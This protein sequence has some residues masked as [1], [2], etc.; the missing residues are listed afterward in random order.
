MLR[1]FKT[2]GI[3]ILLMSG[4]AYGQTIEAPASNFEAGVYTSDIDLEI[5]HSDPEVQIY[6]TLNGSDPTTG[7][8]LY[9]G[10][11]TLSNR[12][13]D[14]N[15]YATIPTNPSFSFPHGNYTE[16]RANNRGWLEPLDEVYKVNVVRFRAFKPGFAPSDIITQTFM[17]DPAG[18]D[19]YSFPLVSIVVDSMDIFSDE[20]GYYVFGDLFDPPGNYEWKGSA[21]EKISH[22]EIFDLDGS[23]GYAQYA[24]SRMHGGGSRQSTR[25][26]FRLYG[27]TGELK[28]FKYNFFEDS[29]LK[30]FKRILVKSGGH[31]PDCFPR[32]DL[33]NMITDGLDVDQQ[34]FR[35]IIVFINGEYWGI[36]S[37]KERM[38]KYFIQ[39]EYGI[40]DDNVTML[41]Q[42]Y[43]VQDGHA[44]DSLEMDMLEDFVVFN[45][46]NDPANY[47]YVNER[48]DMDNYID[49]MAAEIFL[50]NEDWVYS[51]VVIWKRTGGYDDSGIPGHDGR[52]RWATYDLDGAFG[53]SCRE[54]YYTVNTLNAATIETG[55]FSSY[56]RLFRGLL[57]SDEFKAAWIN[58]M[59][60]LT[61]SWFEPAV[62]KGHIDGIYASLTPEMM[63]NVDR[64]RYPSLANNLT[65][66]AAETPSLDKWF[67]IQDKLHIFAERRPRKIKEHIMLKWSYADTSELTADVN[68]ATM[69][70]VQVNTILL[71]EELPGVNSSVYP[72]TGS[73]VNDVTVPLIAIPLPGYRFVEWMETGDTN[74]TISWTP[75]GEIT[76]TAVFEEDPDY[77]GILI[78]EVMLNNDSYY[79]DLHGDYDDWSELFNP[80]GYPINLSGS[81]VVKD[82]MEYT[83]PNGTVIPA[84]GYLLFWHDAETYQGWDHAPYTLPN[85]N[86]T[87]RLFSSNE[88]LMDQLVYN[89]TEDDH[90]YGRFPNGSD[91]FTEF[92][93][94][95][96]LMN[97]DYSSEE[98]I[99]LEVIELLVFPNPTNGQIRLN[100]P[101][102]FD[103]Y[104]IQ[105]TLMMQRINC[106]EFNLNHLEN[107]VY[108]LH[109]T[110][111][112][113]QKIILKK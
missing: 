23:L 11:I 104:S 46:M 5:F 77:E 32:D 42:E 105:G 86:D 81:K 55:T 69:G 103:L 94:P 79:S 97:N 44:S 110:E 95:T 92:E 24:R 100:K 56:S 96:P 76:Y 60:D 49:Y 82:F 45:D 6:Y 54:A 19:K 21:W 43:D 10:P 18:S 59:C 91:S 64:W 108:I 13:G 72:W 71:N 41:D 67:E 30:K 8:F 111:G 89:A 58:R 22:F 36:H 63:E 33:G 16:S 68:D 2:L 62:T 12:N 51:N 7:D 1:R 87:I 78:N 38:D 35:H 52:F 26:S 88:E 20:E 9:T 27:E 34:H 101:T 84:N 109:T 57:E 61:N 99:A 73:Y 75:N 4:T 29:E 113:T 70:R 14:A 107:G 48:M 65:D 102:S 50:S 47:A 74:D 66:R 83:I 106:M 80:N 85:E 112:E 90:S 53:G 39:N 93:G 17:I 40:D 15:S 31:R 37:I 25:K 3:A 28:N 98:E